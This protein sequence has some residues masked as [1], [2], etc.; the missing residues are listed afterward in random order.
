MPKE[1]E[2]NT[3]EHNIE[4]YVEKTVQCRGKKTNK[5]TPTKSNVINRDQ[6]IQVYT[7]NLNLVKC[8]NN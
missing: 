6:N 8:N 2:S 3:R 4:F 1:K 5:A 7:R